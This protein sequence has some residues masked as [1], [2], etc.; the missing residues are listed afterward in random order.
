[1]DAKAKGPLTIGTLARHAGVSTDTLRHYETK[2]VIPRMPRQSNGYRVYP[3]ETLERVELVRRALTIGF[4]LDELAEILKTRDQGGAPCRKVRDLAGRKLESIEG[5]LRELMAL[6]DE[7]RKTLKEWDARL[8]KAPANRRCRLLENLTVSPS[9]R[10][11]G[12]TSF[13]HKATKQKKEKTSKY[14]N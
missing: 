1:M 9:I 7:L 2:G 6:R 5:R 14:E 3:A 13:D 4:T 10:P 11:Q 8:A 12:A